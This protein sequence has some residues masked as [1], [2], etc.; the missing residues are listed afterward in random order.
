MSVFSS[1]SI[2]VLCAFVLQAVTEPIFIFAKDTDP[3]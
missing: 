1:I 2:S 3:E